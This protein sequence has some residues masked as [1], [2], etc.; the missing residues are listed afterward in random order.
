MPEVLRSKCE[1][2]DCETA[3]GLL[4]F[5]LKIIKKEQENKGIKMFSSLSHLSC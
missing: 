5:I 2:L 1:Q 3:P 4:S